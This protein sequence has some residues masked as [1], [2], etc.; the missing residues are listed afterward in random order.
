[1]IGYVQVHEAI[2]NC[3]WAL[4]SSKN[5]VILSLIGEELL[6]EIAPST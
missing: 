4:D 2:K 6:A 1:M 5:Q 3:H